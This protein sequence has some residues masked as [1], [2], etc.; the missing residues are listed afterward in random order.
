MYVCIYIYRER[1]RYR[2]VYIYIYIYISVSLPRSIASFGPASAQVLGCQGA[3]LPDGGTPQKL[4]PRKMLLWG[5][6]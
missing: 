6:A 2:C 1:D 4:S 5:T 3:K